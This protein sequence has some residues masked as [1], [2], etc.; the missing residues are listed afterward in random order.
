LLKSRGQNDH[1]REEIHL[2]KKP[3]CLAKKIDLDFG[4]ML[5]DPKGIPRIL[6][7][8]RVYEGASSRAGWPTT[9]REQPIHK[10]GF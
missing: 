8:I 10:R 3:I 4:H 2:R 1:K 9:R 6:V 7:P 5:A